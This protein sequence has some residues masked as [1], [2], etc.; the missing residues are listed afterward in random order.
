MVGMGRKPRRNRTAARSKKR[1]RKKMTPRERLGKWLWMIGSFPAYAGLFLVI[2]GV[3]Y[4]PSAASAQRADIEVHQH[5]APA[6]GE[7]VGIGRASTP[8]A[9]PGGGSTTY[10][11][12]TEQVIRG[13][14]TTTEW[15]HYASTDSGLWAEGQKLPLLYDIGGSTR[16]VIDTPEASAL[17][18]RKARSFQ[19]ALLIGAPASVLGFAMVY[20]GRYMNPDAREKR[21]RARVLRSK[22][23]RRRTP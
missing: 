15:K 22:Q 17:L 16:V 2:G 8:H 10:Y 3:I 4:L 7:V 1:Q 21:R 18:G 11:P 9:R 19:R 12:V 6:I 20:T 14:H 5:G 13:A 23:L